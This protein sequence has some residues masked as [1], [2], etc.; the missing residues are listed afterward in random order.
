MRSAYEVMYSSIWW[1]F[2]GQESSDDEK[3]TS[4]RSTFKGAVKRAQ[5]YT[6]RTCAP[7]G[8]G[9]NTVL[10]DDEFS[11]VQDLWAV[12]HKDFDNLRDMFRTAVRRRTTEAKVLA[13]F[14]PRT[15]PLDEEEKKYVT[16]TADVSS[17]ERCTLNGV[18]F[19]TL[20][21]QRRTM[22]DN[23]VVK[24]KYLDRQGRNVA[25]YGRIVNMFTHKM[26]PAEGAPK[27][28]I[29]ECVWYDVLPDKNPISRLTQVR[30]A[31]DDPFDGC[32]FAFL[33]SCEPT[34]VCLLPADIDNL[35]SRVYDVVERTW[36]LG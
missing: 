23:S 16:M 33:T 15:R 34:N 35:H 6:Q 1:Q 19:R 29:V 8:R 14:V 21:S 12:E 3:D 13:D 9:R 20:G 25:A 18:L 26:Y 31:D 30:E 11:Q 27:E 28:V 22:D 10:R 17:H 5:D 7:L 4:L 36:T 2:C 24:V 32:R